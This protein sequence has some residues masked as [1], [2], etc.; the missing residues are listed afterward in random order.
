MTGAVLVDLPA[1][2]RLSPHSLLARGE[3]LLPTIKRPAESPTES[4]LS[5]GPRAAPGATI[6]VRRT[7]TAVIITVAGV[8]GCNDAA[9]LSRQLH[10]ALDAVPNVVVVNLSQ[11]HSCTQAGREVVATACERARAVGS[12]LHVVR[13]GDLMASASLAPDDASRATND[14]QGERG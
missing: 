4:A 3:A 14:C 11:V 10:T 12:A 7:P 6:E 2:V 13:P 9:I 8:I 1:V 5:V